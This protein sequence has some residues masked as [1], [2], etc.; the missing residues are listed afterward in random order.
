MST[1]GRPM[2]GRRTISSLGAAAVPA[3]ADRVRDILR[4]TA[5]RNTATTA[6]LAGRV[7]RI[8]RAEG[9][10]TCDAPVAKGFARILAEPAAG[11][12]HRAGR[13]RGAGPYPTAAGRAHQGH[14][15]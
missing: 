3:F 15:A 8:A 12:R 11:R 7:S 10:M 14:A 2:V 5:A 4:K 13:G 6:Q 9:H 1:H